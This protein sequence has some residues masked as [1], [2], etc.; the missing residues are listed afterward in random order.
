M[1]LRIALYQPDIAGNVGTILRMAACFGVGCDIIHPCGFAFSQR[2][3]KRAGM[4]YLDQ[5]N[6]T[7]HDD[8]AAFEHSAEAHNRRIILLSS[9]AS[10]PLPQANFMSDDIIL[11]GSESK[12]APPAVHDRADMRV[13]IPMQ[14]G[15]R[16]LNVAVAAGIALS[17]GLRQTQQFPCPPIP[18]GRQSDEG[19]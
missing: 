3:L 10:V 9:K 7:E 13:H 5:A 19:I 2:S 11:M 6:I 14:P 8:W 18:L 15:F 12:G 1:P 16:S 17:E 4:D